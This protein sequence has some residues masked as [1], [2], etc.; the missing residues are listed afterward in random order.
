[1]KPEPSSQPAAPQSA[2]EPGCF[3]CGICCS[4]YNIFLGTE[5]AER[6][7]RYTG[8]PLLE[9]IEECEAYYSF[10]PE[11]LLLVKKDDGCIFQKRLDVKRA[12]CSIHEVKPV[13]CRNW[14]PS[15]SQ[16]P[17]QRGLEK[18]WH[19]KVTPEGELTGKTAALEAFNEFC[20]SIKTEQIPSDKALQE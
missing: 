18:Y 8:L 11:T 1:M 4:I 20:R 13:A 16:I 17:C 3:L 15:L 9:F 2:N 10:G 19:L 14:Q 7:S 6:I 5:E 12:V